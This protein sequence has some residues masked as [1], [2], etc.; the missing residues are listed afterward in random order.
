MRYMGKASLLDLFFFES[1]SLPTSR[2]K[3][4]CLFAFYYTPTI[5]YTPLVCVLEMWSFGLCS[6]VVRFRCSGSIERGD[7]QGGSYLGPD[8]YQ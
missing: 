8:F 5:Y 6:C 1:A 7:S 3:K 4:A 2:D